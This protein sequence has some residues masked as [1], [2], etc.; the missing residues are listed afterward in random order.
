MMNKNSR[1]WAIGAIVVLALILIW[2]MFSAGSSSG[3]SQGNAGNGAGSGS[4]SGSGSAQEGGMGASGSADPSGAAAESSGTSGA[5][6]HGSHSAGANGNQGLSDYLKDQEK[7][8]SRM[9]TDMKE[10]PESGSAAVD[11]LTGMIPHH[12]AAIEMAQ[13]YLKYG[14]ENRELKQ[15][16]EEIIEAQTQ[17]IDQMRQLADRLKDEKDGNAEQAKAY[18]AEYEKMFEGGSHGQ[19]A[20]QSSPAT[21]D[22]AF[23]EGMIMHH[24]MAVDMSRSVLDYTDQKEVTQLAESIIEQQEQEISQMEQILENL[25]N[26][27]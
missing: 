16:A 13:S 2:I 8:M 4:E 15:L 6:D 14:G 21:V 12:Q 27:R 18:R 20:T 1:Y 19:H 11:F 25:T 26:S 9:D 3:N 17:E 22:E 24:Q 7:Q 10:I 23:A 5:A